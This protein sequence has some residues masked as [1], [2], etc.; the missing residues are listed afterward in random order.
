[1]YTGSVLLTVWMTRPSRSQSMTGGGAPW[2]SHWITTLSSRPTVL[3]AGGSSGPA[4][5]NRPVPPPV[6]PRY[7]QQAQSPHR[8]GGS[9]GPALRNRPVPPPVGPRPAGT[10]GSVTPPPPVHQQTQM[11]SLERIHSTRETEGSFVSYKIT[12]VNGW[13]R[14]LPSAVLRSESL[15]GQ[16]GIRRAETSLPGTESLPIPFALRWSFIHSADRPHRHNFAL[17]IAR[18][19]YTMAHT[20]TVSFNLINLVKSCGVTKRR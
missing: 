14:P 7:I 4:L 17:H 9:S 10:A 20:Q 2:N 19:T 16:N 1:M 12:Y 11:E 18:L 5:R 6:G 8:P 3:N 13:F 15:V